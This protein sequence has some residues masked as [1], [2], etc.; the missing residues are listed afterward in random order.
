MFQFSN[1]PSSYPRKKSKANY[2]TTNLQVGHKIKIM[3]L[4][5]LKIKPFRKIL[6]YIKSLVLSGLDD[7]EKLPNSPSYN[8]HVPI[9]QFLPT[10]KYDNYKLPNFLFYNSLSFESLSSI[11]SAVSSQK[12]IDF[13]ISILSFIQQNIFVSEMTKYLNNQ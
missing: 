10:Y 8:P 7:D 1:Q 4:C 5:Y 6:H 3:S 9:P 2:L 11:N 12:S 13:R